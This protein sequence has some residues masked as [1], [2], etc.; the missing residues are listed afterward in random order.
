MKGHAMKKKIA[1]LFAIL[2]VAGAAIA[3][4]TIT[5]R[6][7]SDGAVAGEVAHASDGSDPQVTNVASAANQSATIVGNKALITSSPGEWAVQHTPSVSTQAVASKGAGASG[8]R[9]VATSCSGSIATTAAQTVI[10]LN[11][12]DGATGAGTLVWSQKV[13]CPITTVCTVSSP[14]I[15]IVGTAATAMTCEWSG[16]PVTNNF[17]TANL[18]GY[19]TN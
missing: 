1:F 8:V 9:H 11:L 2:L 7:L 15:Q 14:S 19:S 18:T 4:T 3:A 10:A 6:R 5:P 16:A 17:A 12:R 13:I